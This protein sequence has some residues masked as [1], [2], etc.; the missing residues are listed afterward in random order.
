VLGLALLC[1]SAAAAAALQSSA[2]P[3]AAGRPERRTPAEAYF[4]PSFLQRSE[5]Y[6]RTKVVFALNARAIRWAV[7][8]TL[9][10]TPLVPLL[11][12]R[13][14]RR[15][16]HR[17]NL[18][19]LALSWIVL[20]IAFLATLPILYASGFLQEHRYGMSRQSAPAWLIDV[21]KALALNGVATSL[22]TVLWFWLRRRRPRDGWA[23][24]AVLALAAGVVATFVYPLVVD[25]LFFRI[26]PLGDP[27]LAAEL[28][29]MAESEGIEVGEIRVV[30]ASAKTVRENAYFT[31][32]GNTKRVAL[33]DTLLE[34]ASPAE[35]RLTFAHEL[36]HWSR[37]HIL[38]GLLLWAVAAPF[39]CWFLWR[40]HDRLSRSPRLGLE[41]PADPAG[42]PLAWLLLSLLLFA[43]DPVV[44]AVSRAF[45]R[46]SDRV[47]LEVTGDAA[48][49]VAAKRRSAVTNL[50]WV[51]P[52]T[53][54]K[55]LFWTHPTT[56]ERIRMAEA[57][58]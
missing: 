36:G 45:E 16:P 15:W 14:K 25:P 28:R 39:L 32:L 20:A 3:S 27:V 56:L 7:Y 1:A 51:D 37:G 53:A 12:G 33:Y 6:N 48:A 46:E 26:R 40:L 54:V 34:N 23:V 11:A 58:E 42:I 31:G 5:E 13:L 43:A 8:F 55:W 4:E 17:P 41:G 30:E 21:L 10:L 19:V 18:H 52:P 22:L 50:S 29:A 49:F 44:L 2:G 47:A 24:F 57:W 35:L 38:K 9:L